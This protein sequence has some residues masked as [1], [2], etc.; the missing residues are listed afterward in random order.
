LGRGVSDNP[1]RVP[2]Q[3]IFM[4]PDRLQIRFHGNTAYY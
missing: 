1:G 3:V 2:G 4:Q